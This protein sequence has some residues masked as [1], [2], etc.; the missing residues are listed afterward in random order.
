MRFRAETADAAASDSQEDLPRLQRWVDSV[1]EWF[2]GAESKP[3]IERCRD[4]QA[5]LREYTAYAKERAAT[6][7]HENE[8]RGGGAATGGSGSSGGGAAAGGVARAH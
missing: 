5:C 7:R 6:L 8:V 1:E 2:G 4:C 3:L